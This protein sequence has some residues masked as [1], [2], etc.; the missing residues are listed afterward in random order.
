MRGCVGESVQ[1]WTDRREA[2]YPNYIDPRPVPLPPPS[3]C[4]STTTR[5][6]IP[7][8]PISHMDSHTD[9]AGN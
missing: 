9:R 7:K 6:N 3:P 5:Y 4:F 1:V 8:P 2:R